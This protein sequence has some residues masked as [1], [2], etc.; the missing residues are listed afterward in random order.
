MIGLMRPLTK[1]SKKKLVEIKDLAI[2]KPLN[3][4]ACDN[5]SYTARETHGEWVE[6]PRMRVS[7]YLKGASKREGLTQKEVCQKLKIQQSNYSNMERGERSIPVRL[8]PKLAKLLDVKS[9]MLDEKKVEKY[10]QE[11]KRAS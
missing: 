4:E 3:T 1:R 6:S 10:L 7:K 11:R 8:T 9:K 2:K 5:H